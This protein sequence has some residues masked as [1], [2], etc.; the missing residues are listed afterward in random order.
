M[1]KAAAKREEEKADEKRKELEAQV[2]KREAEFAEAQSTSVDTYI[3]ELVL[4]YH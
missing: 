4:L 2:S 1:A 3:L